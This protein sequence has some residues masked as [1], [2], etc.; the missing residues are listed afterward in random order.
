L[1]IIDLKDCFFTIPLHLDD[2]PKFAFSV[3]SLNMSEPYKHYHWTVIPQGMKNSPTICQWFV[4]KVLC[5][6]RKAFPDVVLYHYMDDILVAAQA[7][8]TMQDMLK[9]LY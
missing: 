4:A 8:Q 2:A 7:Q 5:P 6:V 1:T 9:T 3:P